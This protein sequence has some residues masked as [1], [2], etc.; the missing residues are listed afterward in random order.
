VEAIVNYLALLGWSPESNPEIFSL[1]ELEKV[2]SINRISKSPS[3]FDMVK[4]RWFNAEYLRAM[5]P[6]AFHDVALPWI[7]KGL[8]TDLPTLPIARMIQPRTE[9]LSEIPEKLSFLNNLGDYDL[10]IFVHKKMKTT[11]ENSLE[12]L[13][14]A[15]PVLEGIQDWNEETIHASIMD[16]IAKMGIKNGQMLWPIRTAV[17]GWEV[18]PGGAI[19]IAEILGKDETLRRIRIGIE[20]LKAATAG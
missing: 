6:E 19:E 16:L 5:T 13:L 1:S 14:A 11:L 12:S 8:T 15:V 18:T 4:L 9:V 20:R 7:K 17:S 3:V 10:Q 2:F